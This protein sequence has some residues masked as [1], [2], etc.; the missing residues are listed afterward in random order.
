MNLLAE[1]R[2]RN[3]IRMAGLYLV[4]AWL[5]VQV[6][7]TLFP[8]FEVPGW[9][10]RALVI[11]L[12]L[13][14]VPA[15]VFAWLFELTPDGLKRDGEV[16]PGE[17][18]APQT[19]RRMDRM[20]IAVLMLALLVFAF[21]RLVLAPRREAALVASTTQAVKA[22]AARGASEKAGPS[23]QSIAVLPFVDMSPERD[24][25]YFSDGIAEE[26]YS[27]S[28]SGLMSTKGSTAMD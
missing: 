27:W 1:L 21:D 17:S 5:L 19:A 20:I 22:V 3:V 16:A 28:P 12:A 24:Q 2:R 9:A 14:F 13:G 26:K 25:E 7:S 11:L 10:L 8:A 6:A 15:L 23:D 4:G 18:I